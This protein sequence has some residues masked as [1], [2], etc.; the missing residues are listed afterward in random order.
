[1]VE[2]A[3]ESGKMLGPAKAM[4]CGSGKSVCGELKRSKLDSLTSRGEEVGGRVGMSQRQD[5][6]LL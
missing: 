3:S 4:R 1:M 6:S 2:G 5:A